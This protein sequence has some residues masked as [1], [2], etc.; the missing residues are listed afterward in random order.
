MEPILLDRSLEYWLVM[1]MILPIL[2]M[3]LYMSL[4]LYRSRRRPAFALL[5]LSVLLVIGNHLIL[6]ALYTGQSEPD[7]PNVVGRFLETSSFL[8][9]Q[10]ALYQLYNTAKLKQY[11]IFA[12]G[13]LPPLALT[14]VSLKLPAI[15]GGTPEQISLLQNVGFQLYSFLILFLCYHHLP[16]RTNQPGLYR[17]FLFVYFVSVLA[18]TLNVHIWNRSVRAL[19][20]IHLYVPIMYYGLILVFLF[21]RT[22]ELLNNIY[23]SS[24]TDGLT[25][26]YNRAYMQKRIERHL[27]SGAG[28]A[29]V[30]SDIDNFKKLNDTVG[31]DKGDEALKQ[32]AEIAREEAAGCGFAGRYGGEEMVIAL[33]DP[34]V[35]PAEWAE[36][37]RARVEQ[38]TIVT[39]SVG[40]AKSKSETKAEQIVKM[41]DEAMYQAKTTGKNKVCGYSRRSKAASAGAPADGAGAEL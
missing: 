2:A 29:I 38:E 17:L 10:F 33:T 13:L 24:I 7:T 40:Y 19:E 35:K 28:I 37:F 31:H 14:I 39:V 27:R 32:V 36:R 16:G 18:E 15:S 6:P 11:L 12:A 5:S 22:V 4:R 25:G 20:L 26:L 1:A 9:L 41:A 8:L 21:E 34:K 3:M 30:F 23:R